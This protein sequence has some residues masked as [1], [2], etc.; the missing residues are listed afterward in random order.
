M[1]RKEKQRSI[2][3]HLSQI[4]WAILALMLLGGP[5]AW[6]KPAQMHI[7]EGFLPLWWAVFW[8]IVAIPFWII[9]FIRIRKVIAERP[10]NRILLGLAGG[11]IFVLSP[12]NPQRTGSSSHPT[13]GW[14]HPFGLFVTHPPGTIASPS[15]SYSSRRITTLGLTLWYGHRWPLAAIISS[16]CR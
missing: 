5:V 3:L 6:A 13:P 10:Q 14:H 1:K 7:M 16:G 9:G 8:W 12:E 4:S 2:L 15:G 11:F